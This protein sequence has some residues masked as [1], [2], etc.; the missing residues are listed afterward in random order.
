MKIV[1]ANFIH[2]VLRK[3]RVI[4]VFPKTCDSSERTDQAAPAHNAMK[5][6]AASKN[7]KKTPAEIFTYAAKK[8]LGKWLQL[9]QRLN[10]FCS[11]LLPR[12]LSVHVSQLAVYQAQ[13]LWLFKVFVC[14]MRVHVMSDLSRFRAVTT[15]MWMRTIMNYQGGLCRANPVISNYFTLFVCLRSMVTTTDVVLQSLVSIE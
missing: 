10:G 6:V 7:L 13:W 5:D 2:H 11:K 4:T 3:Q 14:S 12:C 8:S 9:R 1:N 15:L